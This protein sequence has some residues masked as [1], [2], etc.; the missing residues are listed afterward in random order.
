MTKAEK[1]KVKKLGA[2]KLK[3]M[4][5]AK[6]PQEK[7]RS[8]GMNFKGE[9]N[10]T[11]ASD[12]E[13]NSI[14]AKMIP[15]MI[16]DFGSNPHIH[17]MERGDLHPK[18]KALLHIAIYCINGHYNAITHWAVSAKQWGATDKEILES[19]AVATIANAKSKMVDT[20]IVMTKLFKDPVFK[21]TRNMTK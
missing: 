17:M 3:K 4:K 18:I 7:I 8:W 9:Q 14:F 2:Y 16:S 5:D 12:Y 10:E 21:K 13:K 19:A 6:T 1:A 20:D 15:D 11:E